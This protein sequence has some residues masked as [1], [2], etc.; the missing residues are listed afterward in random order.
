MQWSGRETWDNSYQRLFTL[1][2]TS[3]SQSFLN[4]TCYNIQYLQVFIPF[5]LIDNFTTFVLRFSAQIYGNYH[6]SFWM[7][8]SLPA[9]ILNPPSYRW[10][11]NP[12]FSGSL[13]RWDFLVGKRDL[14]FLQPVLQILSQNWNWNHQNCIILPRSE[15]EPEPWSCFKCQFQLWFDSGCKNVSNMGLIH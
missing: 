6:L 7:V 12:A 2:L 8:S 11:Y 15:P 5:L 3:S 14:S 10:L 13:E 4:I 9:L 1:I